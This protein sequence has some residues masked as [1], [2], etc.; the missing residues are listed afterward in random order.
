METETKRNMHIDVTV[1]KN[2]LFKGCLSLLSVETVLF[3][4]FWFTDLGK[5]LN[6]SAKGFWWFVGMPLLLT[7]FVSGLIYVWNKIYD[8]HA[9]ENGKKTVLDYANMIIGPLLYATFY[10][11]W[12]YFYRDFD[13][14]RLL[15]LI[16]II[17]AALYQDVMY[18]VIE[19]IWV[20]FFSLTEFFNLTLVPDAVKLN[21]PPQWINLVMLV[22]FILLAATLV[23]TLLNG[24]LH[25]EDTALLE[26]EIGEAKSSFLAN[27]SHEIR[28]PINAVLGMNEMILRE[29]KESEIRE[30]ASIIDSSGHMLLSIIN[31]VL[32]YSKIESGKLSINPDNYCLSSVLNDIMAINRPRAEKKQLEIRLAC[33]EN[34]FEHLYGDEIRIKQVVTN[35]LTNAIKYTDKGCVTINIKTQKLDSNLA[36]LYVGV[37]DTGSGIKPEDRDR[38]FESFN[39]LENSKNR[40]IEGTGL[41]LVIAKSLVDLMGGELAFESEFG[42]GSLFYFKIKQKLLSEEPIGNIESRMAALHEVQKEYKESFVA[43]DCSILAVD[44]T[45]TNLVVLKNL[46]K[47][48]QVKITN[49]TSGRMALA[50]AEK[51]KFDLVLLDHMMPDMDG[52]QTLCELRKMGIDVPVI[53]L[54]ANALAD[55][56]DFYLQ[57]GFDDYISKPIKSSE[58]EEMLIKYLPKDK[59]N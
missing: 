29:S 7:A 55:A 2:S 30:Y 20:L 33:P 9:S 56:R 41:G 24:K 17:L 18:T 44:D 45:T 26:K 27:M 59:V 50:I 42:K 49:A 34:S 53:A 8:R 15:Y 4:I 11:I 52:V 13:S 39:R 23:T 3:L 28:T 12:I 31:D 5:R 57:A 21:D 22:F 6:Y 10:G 36:E 48:T 54:T 51:G 25:Y 35:L 16:I 37:E 38:L 19:S 1:L 14:V 43:P 46:L 40:G 32:D 47:K 58:L